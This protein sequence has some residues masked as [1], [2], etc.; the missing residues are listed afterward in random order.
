MPIAEV[1]I[2]AI[3][4]LYSGPSGIPGFLFFC[5]QLHLCIAAANVQMS[6]FDFELRL[7]LNCDK[8][9]S[10]A[11]RCGGLDQP[12]YAKGLLGTSRGSF[13]S[14]LLGCIYIILF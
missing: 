2:P 14:F 6:R 1:A 12:Q 13:A 11:G 8:R 3:E 7:M 10:N 9:F 4:G 5:R